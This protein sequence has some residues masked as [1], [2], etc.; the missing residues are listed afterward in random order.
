VADDAQAPGA[1]TATSVVRKW[2]GKDGD[3]SEQEFEELLAKPHIKALKDI[4]YNAI[5]DV[6]EEAHKFS[7][8]FAYKAT[9]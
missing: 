2:Y 5:E 6:S 3:T 4:D 1:P 9:P 8:A 7:E